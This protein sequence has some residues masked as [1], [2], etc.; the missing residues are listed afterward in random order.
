[1]NWLL[2]PN[3]EQPLV[4]FLTGDLG[5]EMF[6]APLGE[7]ERL[8]G[9]PD[10]DRQERKNLVFWAS[11]V[12][13]IKRLGDAPKPT[14]PVEAVLLQ[15]NREVNPDGWR[16]L[17]DLARTPVIRFGRSNWNRNGCL[18]PGLLEGMTIPIK[19]Q[20]PDLLALRRKAERWL[21]SD[22]AQ[23]NPFEHCTKAQKPPKV[24]T[25]NAFWVWA[26]P[27]ALRWI[28]GGGEVW[29]WNA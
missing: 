11:S 13:P 9:P 27:A 16:D 8:P 2:L 4:E 18:N 24:K 14:D 1:M 19:N 17:V 12:G 23:V 15:R 7:D 26:R 22:G 29:P 10:P 6:G 5:L 21:K 3:D 25:L 28:E 20:P